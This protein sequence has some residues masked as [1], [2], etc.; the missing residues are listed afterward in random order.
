[1]VERT[2]NIANIAACVA[3]A[4]GNAFAGGAV[5]LISAALSGTTLW[6]GLTSEE[7]SRAQ[8]MADAFDRHLAQTHFTPDRK[9][10]TAQIFARFPPT[11]DDMAKHDMN[12][13]KIADSMRA[14]VQQADTDPAYRT[15]VAL[16]DYK[17]ALRAILPPLLAPRDPSEAM[18]QETLRTVHELKD[19]LERSGRSDSLR[20]EG[21][22]E[23]AIIRLA[24]R[25]ARNTNDLGQ[26]WIELQNA[27]DIAVQVQR[28]GRTPSNQGDF[29]DTV[30]ARV[31]GLAAEGDYAG[32]GEAIATALE[33]DDARRARLL[34]S[35]AEI[36]MLQG[37]AATAAAYLIR[38][39]DLDAGGQARFEA[40]LALQIRYH[41][42]GRDRGT[43]LDL[44]IA[45]ALARLIH[46]RASSADQRGTAL[47]EFAVS[48]TTL[49][50]R[51]SDTALLEEAIAACRDV[52]EQ[53]SREHA[54]LDWAMAQMNLG[55]A[56]AMLGERESGPARLEEAVAA[57][58]AAL[59]ERTRDR[60]PLDWA[61]TQT[62]LATALQALG[63]RESGNA[64]LEEAVTAC[65]A[66][67]GERTRE[68]VPLQWAKTQVNLGIALR[69]LGKR[70]SSL[71]RLE[72]AGET[73]RAAL[74]VLRRDGVPMDWAMV[75]GNLASLE[76]TVFDKTGDTAHLDRAEAHALAAR[77]VFA[78]AQASQY[79]EMTDYTLAKI[80]MLRGG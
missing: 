34:D 43:A 76:G 6:R 39:A 12:A 64:R 22:T 24:Q 8:E 48:L 62:N 28:E 5:T 7:Q 41:E 2:L 31:A 44:E 35:G 67:L 14:K 10:I 70:D 61:M 1:M 73:Y 36:A 11:L 30:L 20:D 49:G 63:N 71:A 53:T 15:P 46:G 66:A 33:E 47:N 75:Q 80:A 23:N 56:L 52:L 60:V 18:G 29:V 25:I 9:K 54:P 37:D 72:E 19:L 42:K 3:A 69:N 51:E 40:L 79:V 17:R 16:D 27:M 68:R 21:I 77:E 65:R 74:E 58:R 57:Y 26:A 59:E 32:A 45:M 4:A 78:A 38:K 55:T 13:E 50:D